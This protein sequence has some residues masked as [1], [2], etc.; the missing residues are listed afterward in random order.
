[1]KAVRAVVAIERVDGLLEAGGLVGPLAAGRAVAEL[2]SGGKD[3]ALR[4]VGDLVTT[5]GQQ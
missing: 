2:V 5:K 1:M 4:L 3:W